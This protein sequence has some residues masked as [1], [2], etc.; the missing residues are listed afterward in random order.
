VTCYR[1]RAGTARKEAERDAVIP[2]LLAP[3]GVPGP[4]RLAI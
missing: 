1:I 2:S 4:I 3:F